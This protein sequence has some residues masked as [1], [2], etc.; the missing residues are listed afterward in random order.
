MFELTTFSYE[1][2]RLSEFRMQPTI[3]MYLDSQFYEFGI[4]VSYYQLRT[5]NWFPFRCL[6][7]QMITVLIDA[8]SED[9]VLFSAHDIF[10][11][12]RIVRLFAIMLYAWTLFY[13]E[14]RI[15]IEKG[16]HFQKI[17]TFYKKRSTFT[18]TFD[19][20]RFEKYSFSY[21]TSHLFFCFLRF[22][23]VK[24]SRRFF[25]SKKHS[26][27]LIINFIRGQPLAMLWLAR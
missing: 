18:W 26:Y 13:G 25:H 11:R 12:H 9:N 2:Y 23:T 4:E 8:G 6:R 19:V 3:D 15:F 17:L 7:I 1:F 22:S 16:V 5:T 14:L 27:D 21:R 10:T 20:K 24:Y